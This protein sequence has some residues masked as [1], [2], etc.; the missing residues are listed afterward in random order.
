V[1]IQMIRV[2]GGGQTAEISAFGFFLNISKQIKFGKCR[3]CPISERIHLTRIGFG[4]LP[5]TFANQ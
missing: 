2:L 3:P 5:S 1:E 4:G